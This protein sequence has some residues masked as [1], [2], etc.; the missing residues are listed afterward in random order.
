MSAWV[1]LDFNH[2]SGRSDFTYNGRRFSLLLGIGNVDT[3]RMT[4]LFARHGLSYQP[5][6]IPAIPEAEPAVVV[7]GGSTPLAGSMDV[8]EGILNLYSTEGQ[9]MKLA[10]EERL[11]AEA[12][13]KAWLKANPPRPQDIVI[14]HWRV[15]GK[16]VGA[17]TGEGQ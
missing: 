4:A 16:P 7:S 1:N 6:E 14:R 15:G 8:I 13:R 11:Q 9:Q 5:P 10:Y 17:R 3:S 2:L 12:E